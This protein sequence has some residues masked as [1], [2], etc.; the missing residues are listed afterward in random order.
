MVMGLP[1]AAEASTAWPAR[2]LAAVALGVVGVP[3]GLA[4]CKHKCKAAWDSAGHLSALFPCRHFPSCLSCL[5]LLLLP[6]QQ[7][8]AASLSLLG[9]RCKHDVR[10]GRRWGP[11][12]L[13]WPPSQGQQ[14]RWRGTRQHR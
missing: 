10:Q 4:A 14:P 9:G 6:A 1:G 5:R 11:W 13:A 2:A 3:P 7:P 12:G 8:L